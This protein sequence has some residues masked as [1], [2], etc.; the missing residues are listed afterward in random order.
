[1][2]HAVSSSVFDDPDRKRS[3]YEDNK[4]EPAGPKEMMEEREARQRIV[5]P[6][7]INMTSL[8]LPC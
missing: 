6:L 5:N 3:V 7:V 2:I 4:K 8:V 1:M